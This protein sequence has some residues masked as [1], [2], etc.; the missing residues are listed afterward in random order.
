[1]G[2][3][4]DRIEGLEMNG[5]V[6]DSAEMSLEEFAMF[7]IGAD[8]NA[9]VRIY[10]WV[11]GIRTSLSQTLSD[12]SQSERV[13]VIAKHCSDTADGV[14]R[15]LSGVRMD[16]THSAQF[17]A[18]AMEAM[19]FLMAEWH[20]ISDR[21]LFETPVARYLSMTGVG[22]A[23]VAKRNAK[24]KANAKKADLKEFEAWKNNPSRSSALAGL[25]RVDQL[26]KY[27][28][29]AKPTD[30]ARRRLRAML[31]AGSH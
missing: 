16:T 30:R 27:L 4:F 17:V 1:M 26:K 23:N 6:I 3:T 5:P 11:L 29:V 18:E 22:T 28:K 31:K 25:S 2:G 15:L 9:L 24:K 12:P 21:Q 7:R 19:A 10:K 14:A 20:L 8:D 13:L